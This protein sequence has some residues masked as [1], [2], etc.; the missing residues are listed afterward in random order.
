MF[1]FSDIHDQ[2]LESDPSSILLVY[3][4]S[5]PG[6]LTQDS[7]MSDISS[8]SCTRRSITVFIW[9]DRNLGQAVSSFDPRT[10]YDVTSLL[11]HFRRQV[12][13][14]GITTTNWYSSKFC[15]VFSNEF[16]FSE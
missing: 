11:K 7:V 15:W 1:S 14:Y 3:M 4:S 10:C 16:L 12:G 8:I 6:P 2:Q 13:S 9:L 5:R